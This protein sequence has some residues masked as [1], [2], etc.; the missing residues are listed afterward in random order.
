MCRFL[1][2]RPAAP[3]I[4]RFRDIFPTERYTS[5]MVDDPSLIPALLPEHDLAGRW[6]LYSA[7]HDRWMDVVFATEREASESLRIL[8]DRKRQTR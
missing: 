5:C 8:Q 3:K 7:R 4:L 6:G 2:G 1:G